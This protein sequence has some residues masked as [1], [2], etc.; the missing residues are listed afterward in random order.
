MALSCCSWNSNVRHANETRLEFHATVTTKSSSL[1]VITELTVGI[2]TDSLGQETCKVNN[3]HFDCN[4]DKRGLFQSP[5]NQNV[6][7]WERADFDG[8]I[9]TALEKFVDCRRLYLGFLRSKFPVHH[10]CQ[11]KLHQ[12]TTAES[13]SLYYRYRQQSTFQHVC[14]V[15][16]SHLSM[17]PTVL[18][19]LIQEYCEPRF[20]R[21]K[22]LDD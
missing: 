11:N 1:G 15:V 20:F 14:R 13:E 10:S 4:T 22:K 21:M 12:M 3:I 9:A 7:E 6:T 16:A 18:L 8:L 2:Y 19:N 17:V 5:D